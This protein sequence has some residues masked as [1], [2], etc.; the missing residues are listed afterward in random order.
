MFPPE[1][2]RSD[3]M[4]NETP[5]QISGIGKYKSHP[6]YDYLEGRKLENEYPSGF[7]STFAQRFLEPTEQVLKER[8][9]SGWK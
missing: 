2:E 8:R 9:E 4:Y 1:E 5:M 6:S 7:E 3:F